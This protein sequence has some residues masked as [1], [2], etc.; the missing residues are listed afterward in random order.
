M[1]LRYRIIGAYSVQW[2]HNALVRPS[3]LGCRSDGTAWLGRLAQSYFKNP[4]C[5][6]RLKAAVG[7]EQ[8]T[9]FMHSECAIQLGGL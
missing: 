7:A 8:G 9:C 4:M 6:S 2:Q 1:K 5:Q 3:M